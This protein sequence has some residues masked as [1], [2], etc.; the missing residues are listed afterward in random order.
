LGRGKSALEVLSIL[1]YLYPGIAPDP[2]STFCGS[3]NLS[4]PKRSLSKTGKK[5]GKNMA[6][7]LEGMKKKV[8]LRASLK[9]TVT[10]EEEAAVWFSEEVAYKG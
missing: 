4:G 7:G 2:D 8:K 1:F 3:A 5:E 6:N 9:K 10:V